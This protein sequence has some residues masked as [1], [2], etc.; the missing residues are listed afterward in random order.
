M[1]TAINRRHILAVSGAAAITS[2]V[3]CGN[4][5]AWAQDAALP[6]PPTPEQWGKS[7]DLS[8][9]CLSPDGNHIAYIK[10][11]GGNKFLYE[12]NIGDNKFQTFNIG[13][14]K[15]VGLFW[16]DSIHIAVTTIATAKI[17]HFAGGRDTFSLVSIYNLQA[18]SVNGL[19]SHVDSFANIVLGGVNIITM[20]GETEITAA[21]YPVVAD[22]FKYLYRFNLDNN[23]KY[24]LMDRAPWGTRN[25]VMTPDGQLLAR[26]VYYNKT[27]TWFLQYFIGNAWKDIY[28]EKSETDY[29]DL[30]GLGRD[31][32]SVVVWKRGADDGPGHYYEVSSEGVFSEPLPY[33]G[34]NSEPIFDRKTFRLKGFSSY[35][36]WSHVEYDDPK[37]QALVQKAQKAMDGY[38]MNIVGYADDPNKVIVYSEGDDDSGT[39]YYIDF[40]TGKTITIGLAYPQIPV[41]WTAAKK[42]IKY[43][44]A[45]GLE[46]EAYLT[47]P[48]NKAAKSLAL[49]VLPHGGPVVR[50][51]L[52]Y[53]RE[54]QAYAGQGY[55]VLQPNYRGSAGYGEAFVQAGYGEWGH[56]MQTDLSD[57]VRF[58]AG[59]G[60]VDLKRVCIVGASYGGYAALAGPTLDPGVYNCAVDVAGISD[61]NRFLEWSRDYDSGEKTEAYAIW[62]KRFGDDAKVAASSPINFV[63]NVTVPILIVHGK[64]DTVVPFEQSTVMAA[65]LKQAGKDVTF[66]Q[67]DHEDHWETNES[68]RTDMYKLIIGFIEKHNP[69]A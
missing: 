25:W 53:D 39:Y 2:V 31:G 36:G 58:L 17:E 41:E 61:L 52:E 9:V 1:T 69:S 62:K 4:V 54:A 65:A 26:S 8:H 51:G 19:Y 57:G 22:E 44:A 28:S 16:I 15:V 68:A 60:I 3:P 14:A 56:K 40:N 63:K 24:H 12:Y 7:P 34:Y 59:Q 64:D 55:A 38:R 45:D 23:S 13:P 42:P 27:N 10:E 6:P 32:K 46:I 21:T 11:D 18:K 35:D 47:L 30:I 37:M 5:Q 49:V 50:D 48:P 33:K 29:P 67:Y 66:Q 43:K 20:D